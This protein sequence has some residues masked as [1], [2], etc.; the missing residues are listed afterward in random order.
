MIP[1]SGTL[2]VNG[3]VVAHF[4]DARRTSAFNERQQRL[5]IFCGAITS[6]T[7]VITQFSKQAFRFRPSRGFAK[8]IRRDKQSKMMK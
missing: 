2:Q 7:I 1:D 6:G 3:K 5:N 4:K 8:H